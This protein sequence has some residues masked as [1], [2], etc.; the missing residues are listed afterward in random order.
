MQVSVLHLTTLC[1]FP[2][3]VTEE[4]TISLTH[5]DCNNDAS[6]QM[7]NKWKLHIYAWVMINIHYSNEQIALLCASHRNK[8]TILPPY[9]Y[10]HAQINVHVNDPQETT[11][12]S[13]TTALPL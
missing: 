6:Y 10:V 1:H 11:A 3:H 12:Y 13:T 7:T 2:R 4:F 5:G 8:R 9:L